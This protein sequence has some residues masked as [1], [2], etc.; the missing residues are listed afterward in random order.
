MDK[1]II[2][3]DRK[4]EHI[5]HFLKSTYQATTLFEDIYIEHNA[6]PEL[7]ASKIDTKTN[8]LGKL[9]EYPIMINAITGG[10]EFSREINKELSEIAKKYQIPMALG[11]QTIALRDKDSYRSFEIVRETLGNEGVVMANLSGLAS[12]EEAK[13]AIDIVDADG[14]QLHLNA[15]QELVMVEGDRDFQGVLK[16]IENIIA[17]IGKP[18]IVK[19]VG[20]GISKNVAQRLYDVGVR[21]IDISGKGGSNFIEI[22]DR[23]NHEMDFSDIYSW[24][25]PTVLS[26]IQCKDIGDDLNLISSGGIESSLDV[27]K[28][29]IIGAH[30]VGVSG[31]ILRKLLEDGYEAVDRYMENLLY[32]LKILMAL[33]GSKKIEELKAVPYKTKGELRNISL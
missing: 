26:L 17:N 32:K 21:Y 1:D 11:S 28:S 19:E 6:L 18:V 7:N 16:N 22:E 3:K 25:I 5:E 29:L 10:T 33:T 9:V 30:M 24:G 20:F 8:F 4:K 15:A 2:R 12:L 27:L 31:I 14:I 23:R 13:Y